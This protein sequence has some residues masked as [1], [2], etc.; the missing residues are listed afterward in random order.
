MKNISCFPA[1]D[2]ANP[3]WEEYAELGDYVIIHPEVKEEDVSG[4]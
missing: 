2:I 4:K 3:D 1:E